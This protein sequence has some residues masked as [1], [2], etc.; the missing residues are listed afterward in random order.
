MPLAG[1]DTAAFQHIDDIDFA[2]AMMPAM[3]RLHDSFKN[4]LHQS[5][6]GEYFQPCFS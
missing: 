4:D 6:G 3:G 1:A 5:V 2:V